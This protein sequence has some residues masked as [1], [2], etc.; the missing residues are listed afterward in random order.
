MYNEERKKEFID[1]YKE[2]CT[3][4]QTLNLLIRTFEK[5]KD[6]ERILKKDVA[7]FT[8]DQIRS[9]L[10]GF[11]SKSKESLSVVVSLLRSYTNWCISRTLSIDSQNHFDEFQYK[12]LLTFCY[13]TNRFISKNQL[14]DILREAINFCDKMLILSIWEG[15]VTSMYNL[16][17]LNYLKEENIDFEKEIIV[18]PPTERVFKPSSRL[19]G[20]I[21]DTIKEEG[22]ISYSTG[23]VNVYDFS[24]TYI[25][26]D[27]HRKRR[28]EDRRNK[29]KSLVIKLKK[30]ITAVENFSIPN[31]RQSGFIN[32]VLE[33]M[34]K[35]EMSLKEIYQDP[36]FDELINNY[37]GNKLEYG[38]YRTLFKKYIGDDW[39]NFPVENFLTL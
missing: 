1:S 7:D 9:L 38:S 21:K 22:M 12:D 37:G 20:Y 28:T 33:L 13:K 6:Y 16:D 34:S 26:K 25:L 11:E 31:L 32:A 3:S 24:G 4:E 27:V 23:K 8:G 29:V 36:D 14:E 39:E 5:T 15:M 18:L 10:P 2:R 35:K 19:L 30:N 17:E